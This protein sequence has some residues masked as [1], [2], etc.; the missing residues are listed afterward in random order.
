MRDSDPSGKRKKYRFSF[1]RA[2]SFTK[3]VSMRWV[4]QMTLLSF[5]I[6]VVLSYASSNAM[7][8]VSYLPAFAILL[9]FILLGILFDVVG[10]AA[11]AAN[12]KAF[13]SMASHKVP[14]ARE[15]IRLIRSADKVSSFCNDVVGDISGI[16]S[17]A[18]GAAVVSMLVNDMRASAVLTQ[19]FIT[20]LIAALTIGGKAFGKSIGIGFNHQI[21]FFVGK[22]IH[23][24]KSL[25]HR[26]E[27]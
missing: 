9:A 27:R 2:F 5:A 17:G 3:N 11:T 26:G 18:T 8:H 21:V 13:H 10:I 24:V 12:E 1:R 16:I 14:G 25:V 7:E 6:S 22:L 20:G 15:A 23:F 19:L 4:V